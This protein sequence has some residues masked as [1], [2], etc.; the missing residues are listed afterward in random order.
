MSIHISNDWIL[1]GSAE[2]NRSC[3]YSLGVKSTSFK[4]GTQTIGSVRSANYL[5][6]TE[7]LRKFGTFCANTLKSG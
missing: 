5:G 7:Q 2:K 6:I 1:E 3:H 4:R